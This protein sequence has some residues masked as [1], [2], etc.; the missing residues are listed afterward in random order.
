MEFKKS[1]VGALTGKP[2]EDAASTYFLLFP[3]VKLCPV[4]WRSHLLALW[5]A[6]TYRSQCTRREPSQAN[7]GI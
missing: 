3:K 5:E 1:W 4:L 6:G 7:T 2:E